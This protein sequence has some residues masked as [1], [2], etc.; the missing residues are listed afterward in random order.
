MNF[1]KMKSAIKRTILIIGYSRA[2]NSLL[3]LSDKQLKEAGL[4]RKLIQQG[5]EGL[6]WKEE[7]EVIVDATVTPD[8]ISALN[9]EKS[10][11][12]TPLMQDRAITA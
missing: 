7:P 12:Q 9:A 3:E 10:L 2:A 4:S 8:N 1:K 11:K 6:P 5:Y